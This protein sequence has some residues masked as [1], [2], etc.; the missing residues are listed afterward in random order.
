MIWFAIV[1]C[2]VISFTF[3][4]IEAGLLS[5]NRVRLKH[6]LKH[7]DGA[8]ITLNLLLHHPE[9]L[10]VTVLLV[11]NLMNIFAATLATLFILPSVFALL[12]SRGA[13][14]SVSLDPDDPE[15]RYHETGP[16]PDAQMRPVP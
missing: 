14:S 5:V 9:R 6:R 10:L 1:L 8:A 16:T 15:S 11:T 3:S 4:G 13:A 2:G 12:Q 7:R